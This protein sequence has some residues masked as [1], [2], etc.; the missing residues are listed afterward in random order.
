[1]YAYHTSRSSRDSPG[2]KGFVP[3]SWSVNKMSRLGIQSDRIV[4]HSGV[5]RLN[6]ARGGPVKCRAFHTSNLLTIIYNV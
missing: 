1:M 5:E 6:V 4:P 2:F 3:A